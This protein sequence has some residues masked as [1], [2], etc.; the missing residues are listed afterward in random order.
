M[1]KSKEAPETGQPKHL[2]NRL[3]TMD[4]KIEKKKIKPKKPGGREFTL[5]Y[6]SWTDAWD[7]L[8]TNFPDAE[9]EIHEWPFCDK[10]DTWHPE[11]KVPYLD[12]PHGTLV[13]VTVT[14]PDKETGETRSHTVKRFCID[15]KNETITTPSGSQ[16]SDNQLRAFAKCC[17]KHGLGLHAYQGEDLPRD[18]E[19]EPPKPEPKKEPVKV[20]TPST[21]KPSFADA[22]GGG[23]GKQA[24]TLIDKKTWV[25]D[26]L[27]EAKP[28]KPKIQMMMLQQFAEEA[29][30]NGKLESIDD[31][32]DSQMETVFLLMEEQKEKANA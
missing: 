21:G 17:A 10:S 4:V 9:V 31:M 24:S 22:L 19:S 16:I 3:R 12:T 7:T 27:K 2:F 30:F 20:E 28:G 6:I 13:Q 26:E 18:D 23:P 5:S 1:S 14:I 11:I 32:T 29:G 25:L 15:S 8:F